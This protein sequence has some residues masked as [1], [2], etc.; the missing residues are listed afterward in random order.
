MLGI[1]P[2]ILD[3]LKS[4]RILITGGAGFIGSTLA[5]SLL[6]IGAS[7][8]VLDNLATGFQAN[9]DRLASYP[10]FKFI[11]GDICD[12][13]AYSE[14]LKQ[15]DLISHQAALGSV[16]R[17]IEFP[18][19][20][21][22][23]NATGF[24][25]IL[26]AAKEVGIQ[27]FVY[28][29]SSSVYG[30]SEKSPKVEGE[31]GNAISP[32]AVTKEL[33]EQYARV[34][35]QLHGM[36]TVGLRYFNVFGQYQNPNGAYAAAIPKFLDKMLHGGEIVINGDG[37]QTRDFTYVKNAVLA[38]ILALSSTNSLAFGEAFNVACGSS[39]SINQV[40]ETIETGLKK[41]GKKPLHTVKNGPVREGDIPKSLADISKIQRILGYSPQYT[42]QEG[43]VEYLKL[44][45]Y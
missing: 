28:A 42:F 36:E 2:E 38:N 31:E 22:H 26:H 29:S 1:A 10:N 8:V 12:L 44:C 11:L 24:L 43:I 15:V 19:N 25:T 7:V 37:S 3:T 40:I 27:R 5:E 32:Y 39:Y 41:E 21:H 14:E 4:K 45:E 30:D 18:L 20:T 9:I 6:Q 16:P 13:V 33:N 34:Y 23:A 17:S 35:H